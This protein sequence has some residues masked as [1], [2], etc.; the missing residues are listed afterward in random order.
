VSHPP[1]RSY[2][3]RQG[4]FSA[5][6]QR[7]YA[8]LL[9]RF[10][11]AFQAQALDF[12]ALFG[13]RSPVVVE[14]GSG[15]GDTTVAIAS[16][17]R[18]VD[19]LAIEVHTPGVG[20]LLRLIGEQALT[21]VRVIQHDAV[22]VL[23]EMVPPESLAGIHIFFPDPWPKKRHHKRRILQRA[24]AELLAARL[25]PGGYLHF[26]TDWEDYAFQALEVLGATQGLRNAGDGFVARPQARPETKFER[27]GL[28]LGHVVNDLY[29]TKEAQP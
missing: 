26:A 17:N 16:A 11:V 1:I 10:G 20:S 28:M 24:F 15:M 7:A 27:R 21:N 2:V 22:E 13:R 19:Y 23:R 3:L 18:E 4:R 6:Q 12:T 14:I 29:F 9:P 25:A 8:E 5:G